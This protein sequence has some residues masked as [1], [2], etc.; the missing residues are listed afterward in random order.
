MVLFPA[1]FSLMFGS[2]RAAALC[3]VGSKKRYL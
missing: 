3:K 1:S 2:I